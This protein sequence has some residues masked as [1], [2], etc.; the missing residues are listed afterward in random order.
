MKYLTFVLLLTGII[1][2]SRS[3]WLVEEQLKNEQEE[4][5]LAEILND[6]VLPLYDFDRLTLQTIEEHTH[7][8]V[9]HHNQWVRFTFD[10]D[11]NSIWDMTIVKREPS[12]AITVKNMG[13]RYAHGVSMIRQCL[14]GLQ[15]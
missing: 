5:L 2:V 3:D 13:D 7:C 14:H 10:S 9:L 1:V 8:A 6:E 15:N 12:Y 11:K 4:R